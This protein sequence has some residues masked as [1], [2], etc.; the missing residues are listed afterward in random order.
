MEFYKFRF[1]G[2]TEMW[3]THW[4]YFECNDRYRSLRRFTAKTLTWYQ[5]SVCGINVA[6]GKF[7]ERKIMTIYFKCLFFK[8]QSL[9]VTCCDIINPENLFLKIFHYILCT[10]CFW[11][12]PQKLDNFNLENIKT[13]EWISNRL[14]RYMIKIHIQE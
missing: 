14:N 13:N 10:Y 5:E 9:F 4:V 7:S 2:R 1:L 11:Q 8:I 3:I 12:N 6:N